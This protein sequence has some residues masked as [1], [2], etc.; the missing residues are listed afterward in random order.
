MHWLR[1]SISV[2]L[3]SIMLKDTIQRETV[4]QSLKSQH[5]SHCPVIMALRY[6]H[7][8]SLTIDGYTGPHSLMDRMLIL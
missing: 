5:P 3:L 2:E 4:V 7:T 6:E 1:D 8:M